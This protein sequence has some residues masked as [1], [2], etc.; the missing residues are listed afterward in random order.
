MKMLF[1][2]T[3]LIC[4]T[5]IT[6]ATARAET[7]GGPLDPKQA[8]EAESERL[9]AL[10]QYLRDLNLPELLRVFDSKRVE[11]KAL[12][13]SITTTPLVRVTLPGFW[14]KEPLIEFTHLTYETEA[15]RQRAAWELIKGL[16]AIEL[17]ARFQDR[18]P[19]GAAT[20]GERPLGV[21]QY[22]VKQVTKLLVDFYE[23]MNKLPLVNKVGMLPS[24]D[25]GRPWIPAAALFKGPPRRLSPNQHDFENY[26]LV[27][28]EKALRSVIGDRYERALMFAHVRRYSITAA[29]G[30]AGAAVIGVGILQPAAHPHVA[31]NP[32]V[33]I[34]E[35]APGECIPE[36]Q[37]TSAQKDLAREKLKHL[38]DQ[39]ERVRHQSR[40]GPPTEEIERIK[41]QILDH[42]NCNPFLMLPGELP[43]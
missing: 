42:T 25:P 21:S 20:L 29:V 18:P 24:K 30:V 6:A 36:S 32:D 2:S 22:Q 38:R 31:P 1:S 16:F 17:N 40:S 3:L 33:S 7:C 34:S 28:A 15:E 41:Q 26:Y 10:A 13:A 23:A 8:L 39:L 9:D 35:V 12:P 27:G 37:M 4:L 14:R 5:M 11:L 19:R 43:Y